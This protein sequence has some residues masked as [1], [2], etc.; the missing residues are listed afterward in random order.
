MPAASLRPAATPRPEPTQP[1]LQLPPPPDA[2]TVGL[3]QETQQE[4]RGGAGV[5]LRAVTPLD[6]DPVERRQR[7]EAPPPDAGEGPAGHADSAEPWPAGN[8]QAGPSHLAANQAWQ[9]P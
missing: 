6:L 4:Q 2:L 8:D 9:A 1:A 5:A 3:L 7:V